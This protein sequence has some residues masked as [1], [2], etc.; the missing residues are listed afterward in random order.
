MLSKVPSAVPLENC[1]VLLNLFVSCCMCESGSD[2]VRLLNVQLTV[3]DC[4]VPDLT[5]Y[6]QMTATSLRT[7]LPSKLCFL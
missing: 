3:S 4:P 1:I 7:I 6:R 5:E 2:A